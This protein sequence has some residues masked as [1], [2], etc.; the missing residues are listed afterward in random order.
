MKLTQA[1]AA[2]NSNAM[3]RV[4]HGHAVQT[5]YTTCTQILAFMKW[6]RELTKHDEHA[7]IAKMIKLRETMMN[8]TWGYECCDALTDAVRGVWVR[9]FDDH[10]L[11]LDEA[12]YGSTGYAPEEIAMLRT[13][14][15]EL[16]DIN[17]MAC[18]EA[19]LAEYLD[20]VQ[21]NNEDVTLAELSDRYRKMWQ[22]Y[23]ASQK[24]SGK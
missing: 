19:E 1:M 21:D 15:W 9:L 13:A 20:G 17:D 16:V 6:K 2:I 4:A 3:L 22:A 10:W 18:V 8:S 24:V 11:G 12:T 23:E 5:L 7:L 14:T